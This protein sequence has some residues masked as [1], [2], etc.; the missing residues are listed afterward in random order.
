MKKIGII[1]ATG[2]TG[3]E[4]L[5]TLA[6]HDAVEVDF[7]TSEQQSDTPLVEVFPHLPMYQHLSFCQVKESVTRDVDL[8]FTCLHAGESVK[9]AAQFLERDIKVIDLGSD[10]RF[11]SVQDYSDWYHM[12]HSHPELLPNSAYG[13]TEWYRE[14]IRAAQVVGN[15]GCYPTCVLLPLLP[16]IQGKLLCSAPVIVDAKSGVSGAGKKAS[17]VTHYVSVNENLSPYKV[18]REHR[19]VGEMEKEIRTFGGE[20]KIVFVPHLTP[21]TRGMLSTTYVQLIE[22]RSKS[23]LLDVLQ[24]SYKN[25]PF[26]RVLSNGLPTMKMAQNSNYCFIGLEKIA[27]SNSVILF[28]AIDN[29]GKGAST[30]AVQNMN[31][32]LG[33]KE[34]QALL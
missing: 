2:Y 28:S 33:F 6:R 1:G 15:P 8:V 3:E 29:L 21:L 27:D 30:Q 22:E 14:E 17:E 25:E 12:P 24:N 9:W 7:V 13:L 23:D 26:V 10:F 20:Q 5:K 18:G 34:T 4:L 19:H 31:V 16:F 32:M 11:K